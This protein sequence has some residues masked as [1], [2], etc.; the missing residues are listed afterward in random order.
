LIKYDNIKKIE[1]SGKEY[2]VKKIIIV[3]LI[4]IAIFSCS[5]NINE[6]EK[7]ARSREIYF[8]ACEFIN[9]K[10]ENELFL[11]EDSRCVT[12]YHTDE[13]LVER[14]KKAEKIL[15]NKEL[16]EKQKIMM[17]KFNELNKLR[18]EDRVKYINFLL[19]KREPEKI[20]FLFKDYDGLLEKNEYTI[21]NENHWGD[22]TWEALYNSFLKNYEQIFGKENLEFAEM[23]EK[24]QENVSKEN[25]ENQKQF[26]KLKKE[27]KPSVKRKNEPEQSK[28]IVE[29]VF[30]KEK[31]Y[32]I[33]GKK[34]VFNKSSSEEISNFLCGG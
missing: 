18:K 6:E 16:F 26:C 10:I 27:S 24:F 12:P 14:V 32:F 2:K 15:K 34:T 30:N 21:K 1:F 3:V 20:N 9:Q 31:Y 7:S 22:Y 25:S 11:V 33:H 13:E 19:T 23:L 5:K 29:F 4:T 17:K 28:N 8:K